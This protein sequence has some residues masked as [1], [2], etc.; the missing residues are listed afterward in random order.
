MIVY[1]VIP[2]AV[3]DHECAGVYT[4]LAAA[5]ARAEHLAD[6]S[7][8]HHDLRIDRIELDQ[9]I[10]MERLMWGWELKRH[11]RKVPRVFKGWEE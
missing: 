8:G 5:E 1:A 6:N 11:E 7:D 2:T 9:D 4:T 3:Y 10:D